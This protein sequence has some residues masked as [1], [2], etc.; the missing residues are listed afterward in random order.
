MRLA[1]ATGGGVEFWLGL[2]TYELGE[3]FS[4]LVEQLEREKEAWEQQRG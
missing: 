4:E 2:P 3:Y 1:R